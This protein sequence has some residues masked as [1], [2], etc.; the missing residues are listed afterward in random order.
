MTEPHTFRIQLA[1]IGLR[2]CGDCQLCCKLMPAK[3]VP[4]RENQ[5]CPHQRRG[6]GCM[7]YPRRPRGCE[8]WSC[9]WLTGDDTDDLRRPDR[10]HY[11]IDPVP[12]HV[13]ARDNATGAEQIIPVI[14]VWCDPDYREA[15]RDPA[16]RRFIERQAGWAALIRFG[17]RDALLIVPPAMMH[18]GRWGETTAMQPDREH[19]LLDTI[20]ALSGDP[21]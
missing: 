16:L 10:S 20:A 3:D 5:K 14:Q 6:V 21:P 19:S 18:D 17:Y 2:R 11:V 8:T 9:R 13:T 7:I 4:K 15:H 1:P 12:D